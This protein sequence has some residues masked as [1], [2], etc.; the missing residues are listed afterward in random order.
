MAGSGIVVTPS[1]SEFTAGDTVEGTVAITADMR[2]R[3]LTIQLAY[4]DQSPDYGG[5]KEAGSVVAHQGDLVAGQQIPFSFQLPTD[6]TPGVTSDH[7]RLY[8]CVLADVDVPRG[9]DLREE[10]ELQVAPNPGAHAEVPAEASTQAL[11]QPEGSPV[12]L[13]VPLSIAAAIYGFASG[14]AA[15]GLAGAVV[16]I[17]VIAFILIS[18]RSKKQRSAAWDV[19]VAAVP[20][21]R[22]GAQL[23]A[24]VAVGSPAPGR[25][26][27]LRL[28]CTESYDVH[29]GSGEDASRATKRVVAYEDSVAVDPG[30][31]EQAVTFQVPPTA[32]FT[33]GGSALAFAWKVVA[34]EEVKGANPHAELPIEVVA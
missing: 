26:V 34:S 16:A 14:R 33:Y 28:V 24:R 30:S 18:D 2:A 6:A 9:S 4:C 8:W 11:E 31:S 12:A 7:G 19:T 27:S 13:L 29:R 22:R 20:Q 10:A 1:R 5:I 23:H 32:P 3:S 25:N 15:V 17:L 21:A